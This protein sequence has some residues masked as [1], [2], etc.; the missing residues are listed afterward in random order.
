MEVV[1]Y[2]TLNPEQKRIQDELKGYWSQDTWIFGHCPLVPEDLE[3][4]GKRIALEK[5]IT[6]HCQ[7]P[8]INA[9]L[10]YACWRKLEQKEWAPASVWTQAGEI[11]SII[12]WLDTKAG[13]VQSLLDKDLRQWEMSFR[14]YLAEVGKLRDASYSKFRG[15]G[16]KTYFHESTQVS[17][18]RQ[19]YKK[20]EAFYAESTSE[21]DKDIWDI[22]NLGV[23]VNPST[24]NYSLNFTKFNIPWL[25]KAVKQFIKYSLSVHSAGECQN[26]IG[27]LRRFSQFLAKANPSV[28]PEE[29]D[30][31]LLL[32]Y[33]SKLFESGLAANTRVRHISQIRTF[34]ELC[35]REG[36]ANV[37]NKRLI[38]RED[39]P[40]A[41]KALPRYIP[42]EVM[43]QLNEHLDEMETLYARMV[44]VLQECGMRVGELC[45]LS[46]NCLLQDAHGDWFLRYYQ[47][48][49][50]KEHSIPITR[51]VAAIIQQQQREVTE[52]WGE[53][54]P[55]LFPAPKPRG[56]GGP[57]KQEP[58]TRALN[59][60]AR[61]KG[62]KDRKG[63]DWHFQSHQFRH[64]VGTRMVNN[65]VPHHIIQRFLGHE[66][67]EMTAR[68]ASIHDETLKREFEKFMGSKVVNVEGKAVKAD[69]QQPGNTDLQW[70][71][72]HVLAQALPNG[73]CALPTLMGPC[74]HAN[75]CLTCTHFRTDARFL[76]AHEKE[77]EQTE[78]LLQVAQSNG[79]TRQIETNERVRDNLV[80]MIASLKEEGHED[81]A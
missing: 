79:W 73:T 57:I 49:L 38:Y 50:K 8:T 39:F 75:A 15:T 78:E 30:R 37:P 11:H 66:S 14:S 3:L 40:K 32:E 16:E 18:F 21:Y 65:N 33:F 1:R 76:P 52:V 22:R 10:K 20:V 43:E 41:T 5:A 4:E 46:F 54:F 61:K 69:P 24:S 13:A 47:F 63:Q 28:K 25:K 48:K 56:R 44:L 7:H 2:Q 27:T 64:T 74:P 67:P 17:K 51:E 55:Y 53:D 19:I 31:P 59:R 6:F 60:L 80:K 42:E 26:R 81:R 71:K 29:I 23:F 9:E 45:R 36:W 34:L 77:L 12:Q 72:K 35:A 70:F 62:I 68:Y 58:F